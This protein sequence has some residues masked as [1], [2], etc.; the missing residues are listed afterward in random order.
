MIKYLKRWKTDDQED[1]VT[2][3]DETRIFE[4]KYRRLLVGTLKLEDGIWSFQYSKEFKEQTTIK[5]LTDFPNVDKVYASEELY[6]FF[7]ERIP[8]TKQPKVQKVIRENNIDAT[9]EAD[10]L[11]YFGLHSISNPFSLSPS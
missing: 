9:N 11:R 2:P 6:P 5:P 10:L 1:L 8:S 3:T 4:L 7:V